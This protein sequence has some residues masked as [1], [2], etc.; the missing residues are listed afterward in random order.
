MGVNNFLP[1]KKVRISC[2][3]QRY[4]VVLRIVEDHKGL[5]S[6]SY[7]CRNTCNGYCFRTPPSNPTTLLSSKTPSHT[8]GLK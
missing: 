3:N 7:V 1:R 2:I 5:K 4:S 6:F 8:E